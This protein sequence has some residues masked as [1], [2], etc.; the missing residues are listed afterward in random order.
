MALAYQQGL[1]LSPLPNFAFASL[2]HLEHVGETCIVTSWEAKHL[3]FDHIQNGQFRQ[4]ATAIMRRTA[5]A[6][7]HSAEH[8]NMDNKARI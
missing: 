6:A 4:I 3:A 8:T 1:C 5:I 2:E 7:P